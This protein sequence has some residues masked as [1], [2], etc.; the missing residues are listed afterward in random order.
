ML[1]ILILQVTRSEFPPPKRLGT[2]A[3]NILGA[4]H[5]PPCQIGLIL[6]FW[7]ASTPLRMFSYGV[8][9]G[10]KIAKSHGYPAKEY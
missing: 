8:P 2:L 10:G 3:K 1:H 5:G 9:S 6:L 4:H 7:I